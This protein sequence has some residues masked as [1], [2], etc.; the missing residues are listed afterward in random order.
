MAASKAEVLVSQLVDEIGTKFKGCT[1]IFG[2]QQL[3][4]NTVRHTPEVGNPRWL[5]FRLPVFS[6]SIQT[7]SIELLDPKAW[8]SRW[9]FV[10]TS[11]TS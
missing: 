5:N 1:N 7:I 4:G 11:S 9:N 8:G 3:N 10:S 2:V 6:D